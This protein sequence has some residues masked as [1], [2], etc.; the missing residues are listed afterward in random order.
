MRHYTSWTEKEPLEQARR[1]AKWLSEWLSN[2]FGENVS[3]NP[4]LAIP[5]WYIAREITDDIFIFNGKNPQ[6]LLLK[7]DHLS[8]TL[9]KKISYQLEQK[10]RNIEPSAYQQDKRK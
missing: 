8:E 10:C 6:N 4:I 1:N 9:I 7:N 2:T 3:V 5:G